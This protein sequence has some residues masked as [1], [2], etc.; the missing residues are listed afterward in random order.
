MWYLK[1]SCLLVIAILFLQ[2]CKKDLLE[3]IPNDRISSEIFWKTDNDATLAANAVYTFMAESADHFMGWDNMSDIVFTNPTGPQEAS[4]AQ[5][6]FNA[7]NSRITGD[8]SRAYAGIRAANTFLA[9]VDKIQTTN[10]ALISRLKGEVRTLR[11]YFYSQLAFL[12]GDVPLV[13]S[14]ISLKESEELTRNPVAAVWDFIS[15]ELTEAASLLPLKQTE[16]GRITKGAAIA[17]K[18]RAMLY[19][20]RYQQAADAAKQVMDLNNYSLY[21]SYKTLFSYAAENSAEVILDVQYVADTYPNNLFQVLAPRSVNANS[22]WVPTKKIVDA[23]QMNNGLD[24]TDPASGYDPANPYK[25]RDPRLQYSIFVP[26]DILP[27]DKV[28]NPLPNSITGDAV[29]SSFV[30]SPT[31]F[32]VKKYVNKEDLAKPANCGINIILLRYAEILLIYAEAKIELNQID[33]TVYDA[34]NK[35]RQRA[36]VNMPAITTGKSQTELRAIIRKER[37]VEFAFEG[38]RFFDIRRWKIAS[39]VMPGKVFG[40]TYKDTNGILQTVEVPGWNAVWDDKNY[41]WPIPQKEIELNPNLT[42]NPGW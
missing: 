32:N 36:D 24:I 26:G 1:N 25:N 17:L 27:N 22:K 13:T 6:Q 39:S 29:G 3:T 4:I 19:A 11:A 41:L 2:G 34:I 42:Q 7:L 28:F 10:T 15:T 21:S 14:E 35:V 16:K 9:N 23:Y 20:G 8:W 37:M 31:G 30:V 38:I 33:A 18:A 40:L 5:G 12:F